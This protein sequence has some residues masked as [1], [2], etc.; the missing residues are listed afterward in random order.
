M[1]THRI[2]ATAL[3]ALLLVGLL[4]PTATASHDYGTEFQDHPADVP[5]CFP[6]F[7][8]DEHSDDDA[9]WI[10]FTVGIEC[11]Y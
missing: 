1:T 5:T 3:A 8:Q 6:V 9:T 11:E 2:A 4:A 10:I 7:D